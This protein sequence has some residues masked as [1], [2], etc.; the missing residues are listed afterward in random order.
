MGFYKEHLNNILAYKEKGEIISSLVSREELNK[1]DDY[2]DD[3]STNLGKDKKSYSKISIY[4]V[5]FNMALLNDKFTKGVSKEEIIYRLNL[6][7]AYLQGRQHAK[8][9]EALNYQ[10]RV[11]LISVVFFPLLLFILSKYLSILIT[12]IIYLIVGIISFIILVITS[13]KPLN[14]MDD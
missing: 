6:I 8:E 3:I 9:I 5:N 10:T 4:R 12:T 1:F 7:D 14:Y 13:P 11:W 2:F